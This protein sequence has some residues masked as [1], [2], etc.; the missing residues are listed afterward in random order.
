MFARE[1]RPVA[2]VAAWAT[3]VTLSLSACGNQTPNYVAEETEP[4]YDQAAQ[5]SV[6]RAKSALKVAETVTLSNGD[7]SSSAMTAAMNGL[8]P[9]EREGDRYVTLALSTSDLTERSAALDVSDSLYGTAI[10]GYLSLAGK[11]AAAGCKDQARWIYAE[12]IKV[13]SGAAFASARAEADRSMRLLRV[14]RTR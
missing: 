3:A 10:D 11:Y 1:N 4:A 8:Q 6:D 5:I 7:C 2:R 13:Y 9:A 14:S 12:I